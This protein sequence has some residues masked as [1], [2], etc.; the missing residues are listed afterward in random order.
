[1]SWF[2][3]GFPSELP[4]KDPHAGGTVSPASAAH[5][6]A[7]TSPRAPAPAPPAP[8]LSGGLAVLTAALAT[9]LRATAALATV[10]AAS[11]SSCG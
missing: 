8:R 7:P 6:G 5:G 4:P 1:M 10:L 3:V 2:P 9:A 11:S